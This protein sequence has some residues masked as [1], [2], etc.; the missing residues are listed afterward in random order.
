MSMVRFGMYL[1]S[2]L[3]LFFLN[4]IR[5]M[6]FYFPG[7]RLLFCAVLSWWVCVLARWVLGSASGGGHREE[8]EE[9]GEEEMEI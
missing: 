5:A 2:S 4:E 1:L 6:I 8:E 9:E 3:F 7:R